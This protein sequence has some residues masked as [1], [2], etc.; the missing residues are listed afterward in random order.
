M[1]NECFSTEVVT[2]DFIMKELEKSAMLNSNNWG[3]LNGQTGLCITYFLLSDLFSDTDF[4]ERANQLLANI[5]DNICNVEEFDFENGLAG[6]GWGIEWMVQNGYI[7]A[8]TNEVLEDLDDELY[9]AVVYAK[10]PNISL[11]NGAVGKAMYFYKRLNAQ[12]KLTIRNRYR[13]ICNQ[14]CLVLLIDEMNE[15]LMEEKNG[16]LSAGFNQVKNISSDRLIE[17]ARTL[18]F[19]TKVFPKKINLEISE[20]LICTIITF[21]RQNEKIFLDVSLREGALYLLYA[22]SFAGEMLHDINS[23]KYAQ[24]LYEVSKQSFVS[25]IGENFFYKY[26]NNRFNSHIDFS[27]NEIPVVRNGYDALFNL[28]FLCD[29]HYKKL[30]NTWNEAWLLS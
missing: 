19:L 13:N 9:K 30:K 29:Q 18:I 25:G 22:Y 12:N 21:I 5:S 14:E 16:L 10:S 4:G 7:Q 6:I 23:V 15:N 26:L 2:P 28:L 17:V 1:H 27:L 20:K 8:D 11:E 3:L 24:L